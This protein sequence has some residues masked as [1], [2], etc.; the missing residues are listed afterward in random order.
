MNVAATSTATS[1]DTL[2]AASSRL[3]ATL[4]TL[5]EEAAT[6]ATTSLAAL[7]PWRRARGAL[8]MSRKE[9][10]VL[11]TTHGL[12]SELDLVRTELEAGVADAALAKC[13]SRLE[14]V[15]RRTFGGAAHGPNVSIGSIAAAV[16]RNDARPVSGDASRQLAAQVVTAEASVT[17][18]WTAFLSSDADVLFSGARSLTLAPPSGSASGVEGPMAARERAQAILAMAASVD[19]LLTLVRAD[20]DGQAELRRSAASFAITTGG[21]LTLRQRCGERFRSYSH[22]KLAS[23]LQAANRLAAYAAGS[24]AQDAA[25]LLE[26]LTE[27]TS[28]AAKVVR[29]I[30]ALFGL[31]PLPEGLPA[32]VISSVHGSVGSVGSGA[33][34]SAGSGAPT[35]PGPHE[36]V[37][38]T[39]QQLASDADA[40]LA[41]LAAVPP[42]PDAGRLRAL[43]GFSASTGGLLRRQLEEVAALVSA[44]DSQRGRRALS[45]LGEGGEQVAAAVLAQ[46]QAEQTM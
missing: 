12:V 44:A 38:S 19:A 11:R 3:S 35:S 5:H 40:V 6:H 23:E 31:V 17:A 34:S 24:S 41:E 25:A 15:A 26:A 9:G 36:G 14:H 8:A 30:G 2:T 37:L 42:P 39:V 7:E 27:A 43:R 32:L 13:I 22:A 18:A 10:A 1:L 4:S 46:A 20:T 21:A 45:I 29:A 16:A 28:K 33:S